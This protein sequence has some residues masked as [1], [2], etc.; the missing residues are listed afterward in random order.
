MLILN[1]Y[2]HERLTAF[3][4]PGSVFYLQ[5]P[6]PPHCHADE[7]EEED[8]NKAFDVQDFQ[9]ILCP[10]ARSPPE[11][12]RVY[13]EQDIEGKTSRCLRVQKTSE[14]PVW[15]FSMRLWKDLKPGFGP[16]V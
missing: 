4:S 16:L 13:D 6:P 9:Q 5:S 10:A 12:H 7:E 8:L 3:N 1:S 15:I 2:V 11:K 14:R